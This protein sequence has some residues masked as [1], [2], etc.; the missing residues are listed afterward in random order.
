M[1]CIHT[2]IRKYGIQ[3][4]FQNVVCLLCNLLSCSLT[5][6][7][8]VF[9]KALPGAPEALPGAPEALPAA[10][11]AL[12]AFSKAL[13]ALSDTWPPQVA[14]IQGP[15]NSLQSKANLTPSD[16]PSHASGLSNYLGIPCCSC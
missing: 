13:P 3:K 5:L 4:Y 16:A 1:P 10:S 14:S 7:D 11:E 2:K 12:P 8:P 6:C 15:P 9:F